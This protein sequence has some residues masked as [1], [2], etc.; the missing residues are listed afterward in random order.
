M[1]DITEVARIYLAVFYSFVA[2]FYTT[3]IILMKRSLKKELV[4]PGEKYCVNWWNHIIFRFFRVLIWGVCLVRLFFPNMDYYLGIFDT[5]YT[6]NIILAGLFLLTL[7]FTL[8]IIIHFKMGRLWSSGIDPNGPQRLIQTGFYRYTRNP[9]FC[10]VALAQ[11]GFFLALPS[12]FSAT[13]LLVGIYTLNSQAIEE[14]KHLVKALPNE[15]S[16]YTNQVRR[17]L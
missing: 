6:P 14:E 11:V 16:N 10:C 17:W 1:T 4:F 12:C 8:T 2:F 15:Y 7:G 9:M 13:C 3:R 5:L